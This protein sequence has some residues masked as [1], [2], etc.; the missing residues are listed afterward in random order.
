MLTKATI[1]KAHN[2]LIKATMVAIDGT[3]KLL[4]VF[5]LPYTWSSDFQC[6]TAHFTAHFAAGNRRKQR[7]LQLPCGTH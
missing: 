6:T 4:A 7:V 2:T 5:P 1:T 3:S